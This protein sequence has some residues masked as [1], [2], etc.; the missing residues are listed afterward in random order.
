MEIKNLARTELSEIVH[1]L[2]RAFK[3]YFVKMP[4]SVDYWQSRFKG[5]RV[6]FSLCFGVFDEGKLVAFIINGIDTHNGKLT[7]FNTGTGVLAPYRGQ[8]LVDKMYAFA[9]PKFRTAGIEKCMLEVIE[10][11]ARAIRVY[12]RIGFRVKRRFLCFKGEIRAETMLASIEK[13]PLQQF[14][15]L[16]NAVHRYYSWD[17]INTA[18]EQSGVYEAYSVKQNDGQTIGH[19]VLNPNNNYIAQLE[20]YEEE[21]FVLL[22]AG[23]QKITSK[24]KINNVDDQRAIYVQ[25]LLQFGLENHINQYEM[26]MML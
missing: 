17:N 7:A 20:A 24:V 25:Q 6:D 3:G 19:F 4:D 5:A 14:L 11:N 16:D 1:C 12:E 23:L 2:V 15:T 21:N 26:E 10:A 22:M 13:I 18:I 9:L 8:A